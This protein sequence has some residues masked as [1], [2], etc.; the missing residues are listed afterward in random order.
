[1]YIMLLDEMS[2]VLEAVY[3]IDIQT[4]QYNKC[5]TSTQY[6]LSDD[7]INKHLLCTA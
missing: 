5:Y 4:P 1:M 3:D 7:V 6:R 2:N